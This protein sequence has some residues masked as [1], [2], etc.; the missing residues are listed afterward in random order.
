MLLSIVSINKR[1]LVVSSQWVNKQS[2]DFPYQ[3]ERIFL[4]ELSS[5]GSI[6]MMK[7][8]WFSFEQCFGPFTILFFKVSSETRLF[9]LLSNHVFASASVRKYI[10]HEGHLFLE[11]IQNWIWISKMEKKIQKIFFL[12]EIFASENVVINCLY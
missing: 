8:L 6:N 5:Q 2:Q 11:N 4:T 7:V 10:S 1:I 12:S 9:R 3:E